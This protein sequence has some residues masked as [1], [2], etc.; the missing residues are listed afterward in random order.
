MR[1]SWDEDIATVASEKVLLLKRAVTAHAKYTSLA[2]KASGVDRHFLGLSL[3]AKDGEKLPSLYSDSVFSRSKHWRLSTSQLSHPRFNLWGYGE[4]SPVGVGL[5]YS[6]LPE[7]CVF[8]VTALRSTGWTDKLSELLEEALL[9]MR[10]IAEFNEI[11]R[12][13]L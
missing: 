8:C 13:K 2:A 10:R 1:P 6:I 4:V 9:E 11:K 3:M 5:A 7:S 12:S